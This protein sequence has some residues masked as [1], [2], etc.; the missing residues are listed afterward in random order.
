MPE[1][2]RTQK[3]T[4]KA[5]K[6]KPPTKTQLKLEAEAARQILYAEA[7]DKGCEYIEIESVEELKR[8]L[9]K[10]G[11][12]FAIDTE[13]SG[14]DI[15]PGKT[16][17]YGFSI[18]CDTAQA[19]WVPMPKKKH[20]RV[21]AAK[22][23][24][25][26][27]IF[28]NAKYDIPILE[29]HGVKVYDFQ[30]VFIAVRLTWPNEKVAGLKDYAVRYCTG[31]GSTLSMHKIIGIP[32]TQFKAGDFLKL[33]NKM[34][35]IYGCQDA[36]L[37]WRL[38]I[39]AEFRKTKEK[40]RGTWD[41][42][43]RVTRP[44]IHMEQAGVRINVN[45]LEDHDEVLGQAYE[46]INE[47]VNEI[48]STERYGKPTE[49]NLRSWMQKSILLFGN[50]DKKRLKHDRSTALVDID[51]DRLKPVRYT[52]SGYGATG[53]LAVN[54]LKNLHPVVKMLLHGSSLATLKSSFT[55]KIPGMIDDDGKLRTS[56]WPNG[57]ATGR[58][59]SS[60]PNLQNIPKCAGDYVPVNI[61]AAFI[62]DD[63]W[64]FVD[65]DYSQIELRIP[66][67][68]VM[69][70]EKVWIDAFA[71]GMSPHVATAIEMFG[72]NYSEDDYKKAKNQNFGALFGQS[73]YAF[74][75][76][77]NISEEKAQEFIDQWFDTLPAL[78]AWIKRMKKRFYQVGFAKTHFGRI[79]PLTGNERDG[80]FTGI[81]SDVP[82]E[83]A[84]W[85][86]RGI[87]QIIQGTAADIMKMALVRCYERIIVPA[88]F[89]VEMILTVHDEIL[90]HTPK[91]YRDKLIPMVRSAME[92]D[93]EGFV[94]IKV[95]IQAGES[96]N[97][98][99]SV[100]EVSFEEEDE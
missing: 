74:A 23:K 17:L 16:D 68:P 33:N 89:P 31:I 32:K 53:E 64:V 88:K 50:F 11:N 54:S 47:R 61:R 37:T 8:V 35:R 91:K 96:W 84:K 98:C 12:E 70:N 81:W 94:P 48:A 75:L 41:L 99:T 13:T 27:L 72:K 71:Q 45:L 46:I 42:D 77:Y 86:R 9:D 69:A 21:L 5:K 2:K 38:W 97:S 52:E 22:A 79:R 49:I 55:S 56:F 19:Y 6:V 43:H 66:A 65:S 60:G 29:N 18:S 67:S 100:E 51:G 3:Q 59:S 87:S 92:L 1:I 7:M 26:T 15:R 85:E 24:K 28:A 80:A 30:D 36:D 82:G 63:G 39:L 93:I 95:D 78:T 4:V 73:A 25:S 62:P 83:R 34:Q 44:T 57:P 76:L 58:F 20:L 90:F 14:L 10:F 40:Q